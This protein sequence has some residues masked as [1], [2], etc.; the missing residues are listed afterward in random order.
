MSIP[1]NY[2]NIRGWNHVLDFWEWKEQTGLAECVQ[3]KTDTKS[4]FNIISGDNSELNN[5]FYEMDRRINDFI[6]VYDDRF[7]FTYSTLEDWNDDPV[8]SKC[9]SIYKM[10]WL[11]TDIINNGILR[12]P[13]LYET[14][15]SH[16]THPGGD[17]KL[18]ISLMAPW[19][20]VNLF[21]IWYPLVNPAPWFWTQENYVLQKPEDMFDLLDLRNSD[22]FYFEH[23]DFKVSNRGLYNLEDVPLL[24][25]PIGTSIISAMQYNRGNVPNKLNLHL[26][27]ISYSDRIHRRWL[28][29]N[30]EQVIDSVELVNETTLRISDFYFYKMPWG[31]DGRLM[32]VPQK[33]INAIP[34]NP[35]DNKTNVDRISNVSLRTSINEYRRLG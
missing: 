28:E 15:S 18:V 24:L 17:R 23:A 9:Y 21:Y 20:P 32:W 11:Y 3:I 1:N 33:F 29:E 12:A 31:K 14:F 4:M 34:S 2:Q 35:L 10:A 27:S 19:M 30:L 6:E 13:H 7:R 26:K 22:A 8:C 16:S 5:L 25:R